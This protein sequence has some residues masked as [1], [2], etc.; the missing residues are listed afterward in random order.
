MIPGGERVL[1][2][3][4]KPRNLVNIAGSVRAIANMG[5]RRLA[6]VRPKEFD[7]RRI[8]GIAHRTDEL[9]EGAE[10][11]DDLSE[12]LAKSRYVIATSARSRTAQRNYLDIRAAAEKAARTA[13]EGEVAVVFGPEDSGL[14]NRALDLC[15]DVVTIPTD[16]GHASLNLAQAVLLIAYELRQAF[17]PEP[18]PLPMGRRSL[19][20]A[21]SSDLEEMYR[22]L[23]SGLEA[24]D[25]FKARKPESVMRTL[26]TALAR[27]G[28]DAHES[29]LIA[30]IGYEVRNVLSRLREGSQES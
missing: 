25:F 8:T 27:S 14:S 12:A 26:R 4:H 2:V 28:L 30:S 6:L 7:R 13:R 29:K 16:P 18:R 23:Y 17:G 21:A 11:A 24:M 5:F 1:F 10:I 9:V 15:G 20:P 3:L 19:G 22:A